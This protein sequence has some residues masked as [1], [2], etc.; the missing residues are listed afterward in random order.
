MPEYLPYVNAY[1]AHSQTV[2][3]DQVRSRSAQGLAEL[4]GVGARS[5]IA[6]HRAMIPLLKKLGFIG[7]GNVPTQAY[8]DFR[9]EHSGSVMA[10]RLREAYKPLFNVNEYAWKMSKADL[11]S[12]FRNLSGA[13][14]EDRVIPSIRS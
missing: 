6:S 13:S 12:K 4:L 9:D 1:G 14:E 8:K 5:E 3:R 7:A 2:R 10:E 11:Q